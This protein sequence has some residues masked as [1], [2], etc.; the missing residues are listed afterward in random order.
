MAGQNGR[1][2]VNLFQKH[3]ANHLMRPSRSAKRHSQF[4][5]AL[6]IG[7]KSVRAADDETLFATESSRQ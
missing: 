5:L 4:A 1:G 2:A 6:Q 3:D 7:R